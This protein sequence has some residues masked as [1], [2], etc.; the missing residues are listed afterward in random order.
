MQGLAV[1]RHDPLG[2][3]GDALSRDPPGQGGLERCGVER[4]QEGMQLADTGGAVAAA[5]S[6]PAGE[7]QKRYEVV[8]I[9][10]PLGDGR[11]A[12]GAAEHGRGDQGQDLRQGK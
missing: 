12:A 9:A 7:A 11:Q 4:G 10:T 3:V 5:V 6:G 2:Q 8:V 1:Q